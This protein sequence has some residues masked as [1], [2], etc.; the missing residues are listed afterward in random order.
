MT[1]T[2]QLMLVLVCIFTVFYAIRKI[3][4]SQLQIGD[5]IFWIFFVAV[6]FFLSLFPGVGVHAANLLGIESAANFIFLCIIF[7]LLLKL[8]SM[9][10]HI[11]HLENKVV[12]LIQ[13]TAISNADIENPKPDM[14]HEEDLEMVEL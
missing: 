4:K 12:E 8:F 9:S 10:I 6:L 11:S 2:L 14:H 5:S 7:L 13:Y 1:I 3:R